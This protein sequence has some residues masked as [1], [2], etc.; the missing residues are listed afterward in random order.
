[1]RKIS[2]IF[3]LFLCLVLISKNVKA[4]DLVIVP[5]PGPFEIGQD[6]AV[7]IKIDSKDSS[8]NAS[9]AT[10]KYPT[11]LLKFVGF[12]RSNSA[13][14]FW[15]EEPSVTE[16]DGAI[17]FIGGTSKGISGA[18]LQIFKIKFKS[19]GSGNGQITASD[20]V[21]TS[22]DG[23]GTNV[24]SE[25]KNGGI[26]VGV[27][28]I[29]P[30]N[31]A[32]STEQPQKVVRDAVPASNL[33]DAPKI[34]V[35][36]YPDENRWYNQIGNV[37]AIWDLPSDIL[38]VSTRISQSKDEKP[39]EKSTELFN[40]KDFGRLKDGIWYLRAQFRNNI[41]WGDYSY[42]K[43]SIDTVAPIPFEISIDNEASE[44]PSPIIEFETQDNLSGIGEYRII[45]DGKEVARTSSSSI[46]V[47]P[48]LPG[49]HK[50]I[51]RAFDLAGNSIEDDAEFEILALPTPEITFVSK[52]VTQN[53]I[54]FA[55]GKS[56]PNTSI[57]LIVRDSRGRE[58]FSGLA[59]SNEVGTWEALIEAPLPIGNLFL[60]AK[61]RSN[62]G[63]ISE[64]SPPAKFK[65]KPKSIISFG[66]IEMGW[67]EI[68]ILTA[69]GVAFIFSFSAWQILIRRQRREVYGQIA[70]RDVNKLCDMVQGDINNLN[71][72]VSKDSGVSPHVK[73]E[74]EYFLNKSAE[75]LTKMKKYLSSEIKKLK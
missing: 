57:D 46:A 39:G 41:G 14:N 22:S 31:S 50:L 21:I 58:L 53:E 73:S 51:V 17:T 13:F 34:K 44:D 10:I 1:M 11:N 25:I 8:I 48:Q 37:I 24:L 18:T 70:G 62:T 40:G 42:Y 36:L 38:Q 45:V 47:P 66:I 61:A 26:S 52:S 6:I 30:K 20:A 67:F 55:S 35:P 60:V 68:F 15:V 64:L 4:A 29:A 72:V 71:E 32:S 56:L 5:D 23:Q 27:K 7:D 28:S 74:I 75:N 12:D 69:F 19:I 43:I 63:G 9:Q 65:V 2:A 49:V 3:F 33:P 54:V 16:A 59:E